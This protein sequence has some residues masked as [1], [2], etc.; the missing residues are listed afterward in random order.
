MN[1]PITQAKGGKPSGVKTVFDILYLHN[2]LFFDIGC[3]RIAIN[4]HLFIDT[5]P[6]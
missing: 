3:V 2:P 6:H 4:F 5:C 1:T